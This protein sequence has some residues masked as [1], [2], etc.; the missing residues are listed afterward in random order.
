MGFYC[1]DIIS[2]LEM[3]LEKG[4]VWSSNG[5]NETPPHPILPNQNEQPLVDPLNEP[6]SHVKEQ[7][8]LSNTPLHFPHFADRSEDEQADV[9]SQQAFE[10]AQE[11]ILKDSFRRSE[12]DGERFLSVA[13]SIMTKLLSGFDE[14][15]TNNFKARVI[16]TLVR[17][18]TTILTLSKTQ[19][20]Q[21]LSFWKTMIVYI[22]PK[23]EEIVNK[24]FASYTSCLRHC[25]KDEMV[26]KSL[27]RRYMEECSYFSIAADSALIRR[28]HVL[29]CFVRFV[30]EEMVVQLPLFFSVC[31]MMSGNDLALFVMDKLFEHGAVLGK[32]ESV[33]T[34]G[35]ANMN[36]RFNGMTVCLKRLVKQQCEM[37]QERFNDFHSVW[38]VAHRLNLATK[39]FLGMQ[40]A[41]VIKCFADW[42]CDRRRQVSYK[43][44]IARK[45]TPYRLKGIPQ[46]SDTRWNYYGDVVSTILSQRR[47]VE[48]FVKTQDRFP[49]F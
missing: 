18:M 20:D 17:K 13:E 16:T 46:P 6:P 32:L 43:S 23:S 5:P 38:C 41:N 15:K 14:T 48:E 2:E 36:G 31:S 35:A 24:I 33:S 8:S 44:F 42:F 19:N 1:N 4:W 29:S 34:D 7:H 10:C 37:K 39:D 26:G 47:F 12:F 25:L 40:E 45:N 3:R 11:C 49:Y 28:E 21:L 22:H 27:C 9:H 30:F